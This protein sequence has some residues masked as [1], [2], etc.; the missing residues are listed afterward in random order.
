MSL[1][2]LLLLAAGPDP[3]KRAEQLAAQ[4]VALAPSNPGEAL[5]QARGALALTADFEPTAFVKAGRKGEVVEDAY[6]AARTEYRRHRSRLYRSV[7]ACL[8]AS[9]RHAEAVRYLQRALDLDAAG[10][11]AAGLARSLVVLGRAREALAVLL[12]G[13]D[14]TLGAEGLAVA[15]KA[16]DAL[17]LPSLQAEID[18][19][20]LGR[21]GAAPAVE[22]RDEPLALPERAR[23]STGAPFRPE[24]DAVTLVYVADPA[25][26]T[27]SGDLE[28]LKLLPRAAGLTIVIAPAV[29]DRD[30]AL[31]Q[32]L[33]LYR[34]D[35]PVVLGAGPWAAHGVGSAAAVCIARGGFTSV[36][37]RSPFAT[38]VPA[39]VEALGRV[40][41]R[42]SWPRAAWDRRPLERAPPAARPGLLAEGLS[43]GEDEPAPPAFTAA[44]AA[45]RAGRP[46][47]ALK[48]FES[49]EAAGDGWLLPPEARL[50][51]ALCLAALGR[52]DEARRLLLRTGDSR[53]Q[54]AVDRA[55]DRVAAPVRR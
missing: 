26:A 53:F 21:L 16:A 30:Q 32:I 51:R 1:A 11:A 36:V 28:T 33:A 12:G 17:G 3:G 52:G 19:V 9:G 44:V 31:R 29:P 55:L 47:E 41:V 15:E 43:P 5:A 46:A 34:Y 54:D 45:F 10:D 49:L 20:R 24:P 2:L 23:L 27:C 6:V 8:A 38:T 22:V 48:L 39:V 13:V 7:G 50:D 35:W 25:C 42:E 4:A 37:L 40:E 14:T 18:R